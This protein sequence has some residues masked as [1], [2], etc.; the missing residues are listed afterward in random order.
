MPVSWLIPVRDG[1]PWLGDCLRSVLETCGD[2]DQVV[3]VDDGS[4]DGSLEVCPNDGRIHWIARP[5]MGIVAALEVGRAACTHAL[6]ARLDADDLTLAG[7]I[8]AQVAAMRERPDLAVVGGRARLVRNDGAPNQGMVRYVDWVNGLDCLHSSLLVESPLFHPAVLM[9]ASAIA[10]VGGYRQ[11]DFP[12]DYDL[13]LRLDSAGHR[14][15]SIE[16]EVVQIQDREGRLTRSDPRYRR[17]AF[18]RLKAVWL[19]AGPLSRPR[20]VA[21]W[22][23][24]RRGVVW[25]RWLKAAGH[26]VVAVVDPFCSTE[27]Q[28]IKVSD[29]DALAG[30]EVDLLFVAVGARGARE[31]IRATIGVI[32]P[33][34]T[35]GVDW[36]A[37]A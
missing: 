13:W 24:G 16:R 11:G 12:E 22:G 33:D 25:I 14:L 15:A 19:Q 17:E 30:M 4:T 35:E 34:W 1:R 36:W 18:D 2:A 8:D 32:R 31:S 6:I 20:R 29:P 7:R 10:E 21:V 28:G 37:L 5:A 26:E 23:A 9:R 27:R 3:V